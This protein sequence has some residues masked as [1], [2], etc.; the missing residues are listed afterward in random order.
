LTVRSASSVRSTSTCA[1]SGSTSRSHCLCTTRPS[2][3]SWGHSR[4]PTSETQTD[5][6][7]MR[8]DDAP[9]GSSSRRIHSA[10]LGL[11]SDSAGEYRFQGVCPSMHAL[12]SSQLLADTAKTNFSEGLFFMTLIC[13]DLVGRVSEKTVCDEVLSKLNTIWMP[14][15]RLR[16]YH[17]QT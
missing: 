4:T 13:F 9:S 17:Y 1:A 6:N 8:G 3:D 11:C 5:S 2:Q 16:A 15:R 10:C 14:L 7:S 12:I